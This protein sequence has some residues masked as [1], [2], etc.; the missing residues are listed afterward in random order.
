MPKFVTELIS[1]LTVE[2]LKE[3]YAIESVA[4]SIPLQQGNLRKILLRESNSLMCFIQQI[5]HGVQLELPLTSVEQ[6]LCQHR[7]VG[8]LQS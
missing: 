4:F 2:S 6:L 5:F 3:L 7:A 8:A 1:C